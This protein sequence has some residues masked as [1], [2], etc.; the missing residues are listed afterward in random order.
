[1]TKPKY[2][3]ING[4]ELRNYQQADY[5]GIMA[6]CT[7]IGQRLGRRPRVV[8]SAQCGSG[9]TS[10]IGCIARNCIHH[11][12]RVLVCAPQNGINDGIATSLRDNWGL[13]CSY[14]WGARTDVATNGTPHHPLTIA[15]IPTLVIRGWRDFSPWDMILIDEMH[16]MGAPRWGKLLERMRN[17]IVIGVSAT[18]SHASTDLTKQWDGIHTGPSWAVLIAA[19]YLLPADRVEP[20]AVEFDRLMVKHLSERLVRQSAYS[21]EAA[22]RAAFTGQLRRLCQ[23]RRDSGDLAPGA[24]MV[25]GN[26][27][28]VWQKHAEG[29]PTLVVC[30]RVHHAEQMA[31]LFAEA[32]IKAEAVSARD[33]QK[34]DK[35]ARFRDGETTVLCQ[36]GLFKEGVDVPRIT[37]VQLLTYYPRSQ[38]LLQVAARS[39]R[40][41]ADIGKT[42]ARIIDHCGNSIAHPSFFRGTLV[43]TFGGG[44][45]YVND[46]PPGEHLDYT[47]EQIEERALVFIHPDLPFALRKATCIHGALSHLSPEEKAQ[48]VELAANCGTPRR[49]LKLLAIAFGVPI[50]MF[51]QTIQDWLKR[52]QTTTT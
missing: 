23:A 42:C 27:V 12:H 3:G 37:V 2:Q 16:H 18:P 40:P 31:A 34:A 51:D 11:N 14:I 13:N 6:E 48:A 7:A 35:L 10:V 20:D 19:G 24:P 44:G 43:A 36:V 4:F 29:Q 47:P 38:Q 28:E 9:K 33:R 50:S 5:E 52:H 39:F 17:A 45:E 46:R 15:S 1:M 32:G 26:P 30:S 22:F 49:S 21:S 25:L 41:C 8:Y